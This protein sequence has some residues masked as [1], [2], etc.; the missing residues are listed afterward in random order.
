MLKALIRP[1]MIGAAFIAGYCCPWAHEFNWMIR[2]LLLIMLYLVCLQVRFKQLKPHFSHWKILAFN[3]IVPLIL[4][5]ILKLCGQDE[6][7]KVVVHRNHANCERGSGHHP[8]PGRNVSYVV[9][10]FVITNLG[11]SIS[12]LGLLPL[13][14]G[15]FSLFFFKDVAI[16]LAIIIGVPIAAATVTRMFFKQAKEWPSKLANFSFLLWVITLFIIAGSASF[17]IHHNPELSPLVLIEIALLS[18]LICAFNFAGGR[19]MGEKRYRRE[20]SQSLGQKNTTFTMFLA[21]QFANPL[22]AMGPTFY[23]LGTISEC[24]PDADP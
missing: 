11:V 22:V 15:D 7:A 8:V 5:G 19:F 10:T 17:F 12:L 4:W 3:I 14:T 2:I 21:L 20:S 16:N 9:A 23:V 24:R 18:A 1:F 6:L 13:V